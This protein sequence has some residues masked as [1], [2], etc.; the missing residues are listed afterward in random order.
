MEFEIAS[1]KDIVQGNMVGVEKNG[2]SILIAN[3]NGNYHGIGN[4][5]THMGCKLSEG[6]FIGDT[7]QCAC[8]GSIFNVIT[9]EVEKGPADSA[10]P[11]YNLRVDGDKILVDL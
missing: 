2:K 6:T 1:V 8:H 3:V 11:L 9:G 10:E 5:C 4:I 7:V